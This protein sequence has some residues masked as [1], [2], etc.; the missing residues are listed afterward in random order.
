M[1]V[2]GSLTYDTKIDKTNFKK[3]L[4]SLEKE[5]SNSGT[6][7]KNIVAGLGITK[8]IGKAFNLITS[9]MD[10][11]IKRIDTLNNFPKVMSNLGISS[12]DSTK[13]IKKLS[14]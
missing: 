6:K 4:N 11:A 14:D 3:G 10:S 1:A 8:I 13:A 5:T 12:E 9:N 2:A 7:I